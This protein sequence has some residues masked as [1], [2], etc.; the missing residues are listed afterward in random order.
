[1]FD[2]KGSG[3]SCTAAGCIRIAGLPHTEEAI[4][5]ASRRSDVPEHRDVLAAAAAAPTSLFTG[6][7]ADEA[8]PASLVSWT[9]RVASIPAGT[10]HMWTKSF[11][12]HVVQATFGRI[13]IV[14]QP[15]FGLAALFRVMPPGAVNHRKPGLW[16]LP[17]V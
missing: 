15:A 4:C 13:D 14:K 10:K 12:E 8:D 7:L 16:K 3:Q 6:T 17:R 2:V 5:P 11:V 9:G 1:M